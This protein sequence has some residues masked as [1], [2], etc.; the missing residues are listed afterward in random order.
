M[1]IWDWLSALRDTSIIV[2]GALLCI[3]LVL[4]LLGKTR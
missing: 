4:I 1:T 3:V 2:T